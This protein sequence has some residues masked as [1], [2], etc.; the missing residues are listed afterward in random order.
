MNTKTTQQEEIPSETPEI[1]TFM[2]EIKAAKAILN[3]LFIQIWSFKVS[4]FLFGSI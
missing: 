4:L 2:N 1:Q 3:I